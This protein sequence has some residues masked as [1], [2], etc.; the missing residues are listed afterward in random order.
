MLCDKCKKRTATAYVKRTVNGV[1]TELHLCPVCAAK[2]EIDGGLFNMLSGVFGET[3]ATPGIGNT[4][5]CGLC[6]R[7]F[8]EIAESGRLGCAECYKVFEKQ[9]RPSLQRLHGSVRHIG[10][11]SKYAPK[12][13]GTAEEA[14]QSGER[15][16]DRLKADLKT[17]IANE[18][19]EKAAEIRD[20]IKRLEAGEQ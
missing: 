11:R 8:E 20:E 12:P 5:R 1:T 2:E 16:I 13:A 17:A 4:V 3:A 9:L 15:K 7:S 19:Y 14:E 6:G 18:A 10:K